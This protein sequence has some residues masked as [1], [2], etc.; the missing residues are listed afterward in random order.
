M[1]ANGQKSSIGTMIVPDK[2]KKIIPLMLDAD[3]DEFPDH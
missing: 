1:E 3:V 2:V